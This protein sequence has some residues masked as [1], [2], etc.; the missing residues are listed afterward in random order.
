ME[1]LA[2]NSRM[3]DLI[4]RGCHHRDITTILI[5]QNLFSPGKY[6]RTIPLNAH[7]IIV[8]KNPRD[9]LGISTLARQAFPN[10]VNY[11]MESY[12]NAVKEPFS[13]LLIDLFQ[14]TPDHCRLSANFPRGATDCVR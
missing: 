3:S 14:T 1:T 12:E 2:K 8:F 7:Y 10:N 11:V 4:T 9:P 5:I 13:Y 6:S